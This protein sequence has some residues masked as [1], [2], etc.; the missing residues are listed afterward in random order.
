MALLLFAFFMVSLPVTLHATPAPLKIFFS[1]NVQGET[2]P[3]G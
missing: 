1:G 2:E 3:C